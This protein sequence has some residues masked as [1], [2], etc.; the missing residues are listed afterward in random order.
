MQLFPRKF[1]FKK[2]FR[3]KALRAVNSP[4]NFVC[5]HRRVVGL[6]ATQPGLIS[7]VQLQ[8]FRLCVSKHLKKLGTCVFYTFPQMTKSRKASGGRM[9]K[10]KGSDK[11]WF[12]RFK[13]GFILCTVH[14]AGTAAGE[15]A[16]LS[17]RNRLPLQTKI[18]L[19]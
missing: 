19:L 10:G 11:S 17:A 18:V 8:A 6:Y 7:A 13:V 9:G 12:C 16:L 15:R 4:E 14:T 5:C 1:K 2:N 3:V